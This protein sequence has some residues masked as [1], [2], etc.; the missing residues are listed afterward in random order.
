MSWILTAILC[1]LLIEILIRVPL[2]NL[3]V[4]M[5]K[6]SGKS[7]RI[8]RSD[9][10]SDHWKE[11]VMLMYASLLISYTLKLSGIF[12]VIGGF[13]SILV[14]MS[15][16]FDVAMEQFVLSWMGVVYSLLVA[17]AYLKLRKAFV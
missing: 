6:V 12:L 9:K 17:M 11:K 15:E 5:F 2:K 3:L 10:I 16:Y 13:A 1:V 14:Y 7:L 4:E 8:L